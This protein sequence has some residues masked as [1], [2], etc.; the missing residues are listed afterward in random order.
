MSDLAAQV[1]ATQRRLWVNRWL[2]QVGCLL[3]VASGLWVMILL[4]QRAFSWP[5]PLWALAGIGAALALSGSVVWLRATRESTH[6][7]A[8][9]LDGAAGLKE[10]VSSALWCV[11]QENEFARAVCADAQRTVASVRPAACVPA[12]WP[13]SLTGGLSAAGAAVLLGWLLP[14]FD[15]LGRAAARRAEAGREAQVAAVKASLAETVESL[16]K[17]A[18][19]AG[20]EG[21]SGLEEMEKLTRAPDATLDPADLRREAIKRLDAVGNDLRRA[22][23]TDRYQVM[24]QT[25]ERLSEIEAPRDARSPAGRLAQALADGDFQS[26]QREV[27]AMQEQLARRK[28]GETDAQEVRRLAAQLDELAA[29]LNDLADEKKLTEQ[30]KKSGLSDDELK[31]VLD[32]LA[33]KDPKQL[34][35]MLSELEKRLGEKGLSKQQIERLK[36]R[37]RNAAGAN[38]QSRKACRDLGRLMQAAGA[39]ARAGETDDAAESLGEAAEQL[40]ALEQIEQELAEIESKSAALDQL[41][42]SLA[43]SQDRAPCRHCN[44]SGR[45]E[46]G[47]PCGQ[48]NGDG[49]GGRGRGAG[50]RPIAE[51]ADVDFVKRRAKVLQRPGQ[52][53]GQWY[54][55]GQQLRGEARAEWVD[56][57]EAAV[58]D[59]TD[60]LRKD[61]V[62]RAYQSAVKSYFD[63]LPET[64]PPAAG[65]SP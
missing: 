42:D 26:A 21:L 35:K 58:R 25:R 36:Q 23:Q 44:G 1:R 16:K 47:S 24:R 4:L 37:T 13:R 54:V 39:A 52:V 30:L 17:T 55:Q 32:A 38:Q 15:L 53:I 3:M 29:R 34:E 10:R 14:E 57:T 61:Q 22:G 31:R 48:C 45:C 46:D 63:R 5:L 20:L 33:K 59:A 18:S 9:R 62:P 56:A 41:R 7:A 49:P 64:V 2:E 6:E 27:R 50:Q 8:V 12:R 60:A 43:E 65:P 40:S 19:G 11:G 28:R 51:T